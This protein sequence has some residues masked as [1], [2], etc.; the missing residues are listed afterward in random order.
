MQLS[1][2]E[3]INR[4]LDEVYT[5]VRDNLDKLVPHMPNIGRIEVKSRKENGGKI[6]VTNHWF[7]KAEMPSLL[8]KFLNPDIFSWKDVAVWDNAAHKV[9]YRLES[10]V[11]NDLFE[12]KGTNS[13]KAVG[14]DKTELTISCNIV[15]H[16]DKVPGVPKLLAR[17]VT[18]AIEALLEK[19][20]APNMTALGKGL[21]QYFGSK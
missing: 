14:A 19:M 2:T 15:I 1:N 6:E 3:T 11:A 13:F 21:N 4:P 5:L 17:Q 20:L 9:D 10:F 12:A 8:K 18:P 16:A 7:A